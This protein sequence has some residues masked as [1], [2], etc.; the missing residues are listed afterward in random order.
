MGARQWRRGK[1]QQRER[2]EIGNKIL[3]WVRFP[4]NSVTRCGMKATKL[5]KKLK[6]TTTTSDFIFN[7]EQTPNYIGQACGWIK[8]FD[9]CFR[10]F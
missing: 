3:T 1:A 2:Q 10:M 9:R 7:I 8:D 4:R 6:K 5:K